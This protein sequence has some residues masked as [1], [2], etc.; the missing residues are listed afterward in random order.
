VNPP[1]DERLMAFLEGRMD[2]TERA[3]LLDEL[4]ADPELSRRLR[5]A[6]AGLSAL[7]GYAGTAR[8]GQKKTTDG[9]DPGRAVPGR[10]VPRWWIPAAMAATLAL[11]VPGTLWLSGDNRFATT[12]LRTGIPES[13]Q[14]SFVLVLHGRW[15]DRDRVSAAEARARATEYWAWTSRLA[16][17]GVLLAAG[18]L[19]WEPGERLGPEGTSVAVSADELVQP[20]FIV[21]MLALRAT[22]YQQALSLARQC[23]HLRYGGS[24]S[25]REVGS[26]FVTVPG[27]GD[28]TD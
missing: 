22:S 16:D 10:A 28:W 7:S 8:V 12:E 9:I 23:P 1:S 5:A 27:M 3:S 14:P 4:D 24:V 25:I 26:G 11:A 6:A 15:P 21:G 20:D 17:E 18:D 2:E 13:P 19:R